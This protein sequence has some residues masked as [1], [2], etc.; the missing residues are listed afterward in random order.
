MQFLLRHQ[1]VISALDKHH[2]YYYFRITMASLFLPLYEET[3]DISLGLSNHQFG[4]IMA[5]A[6][7]LLF[8]PVFSCCHLAPAA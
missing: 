6:R 7:T 1:A 8:T 2:L 5:S 4:V 3:F